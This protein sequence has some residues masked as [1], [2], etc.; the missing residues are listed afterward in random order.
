MFGSPRRNTSFNGRDLNRCRRIQKF[1]LIWL[2]VNMDSSKGDDTFSHSIAD[3]CDVVSSIHTFMDIDE[4]I[5]FLTD[6]K[7]EKVIMILHDEVGD[8]VMSS[9]HQISQL[10]AVFILSDNKLKYKQTMMMDWSKVKGVFTDVT[11]ISKSIKRLLR[12]Y[13][14]DNILFSCITAE[15]VMSP[16]LDQLPPSFMYT[17]LIKETLFDMEY[18]ECCVKNLATYCRQLSDEQRFNSQAITE[19]E[20]N[21]RSDSAIWWYTSQYFIYSTVNKALRNLDTQALVKMAFFIRDL[22][23]QLEQLHK[24]QLNTGSTSQ[25]FTVYR[26]QGLFGEDFQKLRK[27]KGGLL[28]FNNFLS[29]SLNRDISYSFALSVSDITSLIPI[30][31]HITVDPSKSTTPFACIDYFSYYSDE[32]E[33]LFSMN[34]V[35]R[36]DEI[37]QDVEHERLYEVKLTLTN[38]NDPQLSIL[39][40]RMREELKGVGWHR[41][42]QLM[43]QVGDF[44]AAEQLYM[45]LLKNTNDERDNS[46]YIDRLATAKYHQGE[47]EEALK[48]FQ[49]SIEID[50]PTLG[51]NHPSLSDSYNNI[52]L[53]YNDMGE[54][55]KALEYYEKTCKIDETALPN[56]H[57]DLATSHNNI[58]LVYNNMGEYSK[59]LEYYEK[60]I[61]I[62]K[63]ALPKNH[64]DLATSY[65]NIGQVYNNM[66]EYSKALEYYEKDIGIKKIALPKN[67]PD[68]AISYSNI[69][70]VYNKMGEYSKALKYYEKSIEIRKIALPEN[71]PDLATSYS[72]IGQVYN[73]MGEYSKA[74]EYYEKDIE[75]KKL[76][77]PK[78]HPDFANSYSNIGQVYNKMGEYSK[79]LEYY[80]KS[81]EIRKIA[82]PE[83][84]PDLAIS[85]SNIGQVYNKMGEY[86][87]A[88]EYCEK[89]IQ[90][91]K[92][93]LPKDHPDFAISYSNIGQVYNKM[94]D[95]SKALEY[96]KKDIEI[97]KLALPKNHPDF[98]IS[99]SNIGQ[100]YKDMDEYL[101]AL[102]YYEKT[103]KIFEIHV[104]LPKNHPDFA[105]CYSNIGQLYNRLGECSIALEY[106]E[107]SHK[108]FE[109]AL[110]KN[111]AY[112][113]NSY[114][115]MGQ[116]YNRMGEYSKALKYYEKS[117]EIRKIALPQ[118]HPSFAIS[119]MNF[120][121]VYY[122]MKKYREALELF[123][124]ALE[125][126]LEKL[127]E[128]HPQITTTKRWIELVKQKI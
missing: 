96:Y 70:Q 101:K 82:L 119:Y 5:D 46:A 16:N 54:Y 66:G 128:A 24:Q 114:S 19:F 91:K 104:A 45:E 17:Q 2:D 69:G 43:L 4:C 124:K 107:K 41:M 13:D 59:A 118:E 86:L 31:F 7:Y 62:R 20:Q 106:Y 48:Y 6:V 120:G 8:N 111:H 79:A 92:L 87:A 51:E 74:L 58:A 21:Y 122:N 60:S 125:I 72:N 99:Y 15:N 98:A 67:H 53:V 80:E 40:Q 47:Y 117:I 10:I 42:G 95:Y 68:F 63:I 30:L 38:D 123:R 1:L 109:I 75:I 113:A 33:I 64:P 115:D 35:F 27:T 25:A 94:G 28:S 71:H 93:A 18:P 110:P 29:T 36:I 44:N 56:N 88:L 39:K 23:R 85:Y 12:R 52:A 34:A 78:N 97:K 55:S 126:Q 26:G 121:S 73:K 100:V 65:S 127:P 9:L 50:E 81:I 90:I 61:E 22:H 57:P 49:K 89:D 105:I 76:A 14:K 83:N 11:R 3:L 77:L 103:H 32:K 102:K 116:V 37:T 84:H 112:L 108:I